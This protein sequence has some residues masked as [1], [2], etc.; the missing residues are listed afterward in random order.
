MSSSRAPTRSHARED[1]GTSDDARGVGGRVRVVARV[2]AVRASEGDE[3]GGARGEAGAPL[4]RADGA[5]VTLVRRRA[6]ASACESVGFRGPCV[7]A[8]ST[9]REFYD[10]SGIDAMVEKTMAGYASCVFAYG[11]TGS[12]KT[13]TMLGTRSRRRRRGRL[14]SVNGAW[15]RRGTRWKARERGVGRSRERR[16]A[17]RI[18]MALG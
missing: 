2:R 5:R 16:S 10:A 12:G 6:G 18:C 17:R 15:A 14:R 1:D 4:A 3:G 7:G 11:Q 8:A 9:Q 13:Y